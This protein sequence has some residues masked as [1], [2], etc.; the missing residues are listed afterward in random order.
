MDFL[1]AEE[2]PDFTTAEYRE[3]LEIHRQSDFS[4]FFENE[5][6]VAMEER[7]DLETVSS[8]S[9]RA[10]YSQHPVYVEHNADDVE[11]V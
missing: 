2:R 4:N 7:D 8:R 3:T 6:E 9:C 10:N 11:A 5:F 1:G